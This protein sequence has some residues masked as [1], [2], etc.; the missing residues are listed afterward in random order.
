[1]TFSINTLDTVMLSV[2]YAMLF[3]LSV[4]N[5]LMLLSVITL[6]VVLLNVMASL[7]YSLPCLKVLD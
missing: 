3:M 5:K 2:V 4:A 1:M 6:S 7:G